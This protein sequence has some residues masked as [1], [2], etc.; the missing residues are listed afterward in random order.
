MRRLRKYAV[1]VFFVVAV[2]SASSLFAAPA[3]D[4]G[5]VQT[6]LAKLKTAIFHILDL[7]GMSV[8]PG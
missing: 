1:G 4:V 6:V 8:P 7:N 5:R 2:F 3:K